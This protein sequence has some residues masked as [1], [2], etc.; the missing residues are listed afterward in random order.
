MGTVTR[1][2]HAVE[3]LRGV[4]DLLIGEMA[5]V[6]R[7]ATPRDIEIAINTKNLGICATCDNLRCRILTDRDRFLFCWTGADVNSQ[8]P[9][10]DMYSHKPEPICHDCRYFV[11]EGNLRGAHVPL[12][13]RLDKVG[14]VCNPE[15]VCSFFRQRDE[16]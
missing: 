10:C 9:L 13:N 6:E 5:G 12:C 11:K 4:I 1:K 16:P 15:K 2:N 7:K 3:C 8:N 14:P